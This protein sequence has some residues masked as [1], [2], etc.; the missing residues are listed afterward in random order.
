M[1]LSYL[2]SFYVTISSDEGVARF[3]KTRDSDFSVLLGPETVLTPSDWEVGLATFTYRYDF[4]TVGY[5]NL[6]AVRYRD[7]VHEIKIPIWNCQSVQQLAEYL[8]VELNKKI[9]Y[10]QRI[11]DFKTRPA[12]VKVDSFNRIRFSFD[13]E[14]LDL[15]FAP[16][17]AAL[18]GFSDQLHVSMTAFQRRQK[19]RKLMKGTLAADEKFEGSELAK[20]QMQIRQEPEHVYSLFFYPDF[21]RTFQ[22][23][24]FHRPLEQA[25]QGLFR[26]LTGVTKNR[27]KKPIDDEINPQPGGPKK[28]RFEFTVQ[29]PD[30]TN[31]LHQNGLEIG[32]FDEENMKRRARALLDLVEDADPVKDKPIPQRKFH[33]DW[34]KNTPY[35]GFFNLEELDAFVT[36]FEDQ[37]P[38]EDRTYFNT[39]N[40]TVSYSGIYTEAITAFICSKFLEDFQLP[41]PVLYSN[42]PASL[43]PVE[44]MYVYL[45][46]IKPE[47]V[48]NLM[49]PLLEI[50]RT[51]GVPGR[52]TQYRAGGHLQ[53]KA[54]E[55]SNITD[56][57]VLIASKDG[58]RIPFLRGP[59]QLQLHF[60]KKPRGNR[61]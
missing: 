34:L 5:D 14:D 51:E 49:S 44:L 58:D 16:E 39:S 59:T 25:K 17:T 15:G 60:R 18:L 28:P 9:L 7:A 23:V 11:K 13:T 2:E 45:D 37:I 22:N 38:E 27:F 24:D 48:N 6:I 1:A 29:L 35:A 43:I 50:I 32:T 42:E 33:L 8:D 19:L 56:L 61:H 55:K 31:L 30:D 4:N 26:T 47:P 41:S 20:L 3:P 53:Y 54:I 12:E 57:R 52:L 10:G 36:K 46:I 21:L 40:L